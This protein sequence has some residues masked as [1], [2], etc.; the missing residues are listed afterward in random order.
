LVG[1]AVS[2]LQWMGF[3]KPTSGHGRKGE[4]VTKMVF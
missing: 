3:I 1:R 4:H 2:E